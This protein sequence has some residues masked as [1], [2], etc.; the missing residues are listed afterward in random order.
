MNTARTDFLSDMSKLEDAIMNYKYEYPFNSGAVFSLHTGTIMMILSLALIIAGDG[1]SFYIG[2][3]A[4]VGFIGF[5]VFIK[6]YNLNQKHANTAE[7]YNMINR[8]EWN[9]NGYPDVKEYI[10]EF[11][12]RLAAAVKQK[13]KAE[14][15]LLIV[16]FAIIA[17]GALI[18]HSNIIRFIQSSRH[19]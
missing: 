19:P 10:A 8:I 5:I 12:I 15:A 14:T 7:V 9:Y 6:R 18:G 13:Q 1:K 16:I 17:L 4:I 3:A 11:R 2:I